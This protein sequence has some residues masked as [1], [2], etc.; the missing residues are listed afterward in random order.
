MAKR[1]AIN[2]VLT[3][4]GSEAT[5][6]DIHE[7]IV[8]SKASLRRCKRCKTTKY[9]RAEAHNAAGEVIRCSICSQASMLLAHSAQECFDAAQRQMYEQSARGHHANPD[10]TQ[11]RIKA[12]IHA[13]KVGLYWI[14]ILNA[15]QQP[16]AEAPE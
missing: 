15:S 10:A 5:P 7:A 13:A 16:T 4:L 9:A 11:Q 6:A 3:Q 14:G 2:D 1:D 12:A 8:A